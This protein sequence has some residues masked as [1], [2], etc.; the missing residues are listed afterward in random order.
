MATATMNVCKI[1]LASNEVSIKHVSDVMD[2]ME[3]HVIVH[4]PWLEFDYLPKV[5]FSIG[6]SETHVFV[7]Y[8]VEEREIR[9]TVSTDQGSVWED[10]CVEF[11]VSFPDDDAA[12]YN[13]EFNCLGTCFASF[14]K[15]K[16]DRQLLAVKIMK[17]I[18]THSSIV[19][20]ESSNIQWELAV[21]I[22]ISSFVH[23]SV[24]SLQGTQ[25]RANFYK[26]G[27][28]LSKP[29]FVAWSN[30][31]SESPNFHLPAYFGALYFK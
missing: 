5:T 14:G 31:E 16:F 18:F 22:P 20:N 9:A 15:S 4:K 1:P 23:S 28:L 11:F 13:F 19:C 12:Y 10:S 17:D 2:S 7:K 21:A 29:H 6:Y 30:I 8:Y 3:K 25:C 24:H 27:D 26:C